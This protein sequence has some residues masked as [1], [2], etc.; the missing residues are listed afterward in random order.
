MI[1]LSDKIPWFGSKTGY[2]C[3]P[4]QLRSQDLAVHEICPRRT[5]FNRAVG[6]MASLALRSGS[7]DQIASCGRFYS[8]LSLL[9]NR[10]QGMHILYGEVHAPA[11]GNYPL[12][13]R[14]RTLLTFHQPRSQWV[15]EKL[16]DLKSVKHALF[17]Y[18]RDMAFFSDQ[19]PEAEV[20]FIPHGADTDFF[21][22]SEYKDG[23]SLRVLYNG[24]HLR[25]IAM[26]RRLFP[27]LH[28]RFPEVRFDFLVPVHRRSWEAFG[29]LLSHPSITWH[30]GLDDNQ[31]LALYQSADL[32]W[33]PMEDSGAN[34]AV[35]EALAC[36]LP[37]V[38]TDVGGIRD[39][40][41]GTIYPLVKNDDDQG[42]FKELETLI[43]RDD[44]RT[45]RSHAARRFTEQFLAWPEIAKKHHMLY[46]EL[47]K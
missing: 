10:R 39:Y 23:K 9:A 11:W 27:E 19:M 42:M 26:L 4:Q 43:T 1:L 20:H 30:S 6:K 22:P 14:Q 25:N 15:P 34:T 41:G 44:V 24:V 35:V 29:E 5:L 32:L 33:L 8:A 28:S 21:R 2:E 31:L 36:G 12:T 16:A 37:I 7:C 38:T 3:L 13:L 40:G 18:Q 17:L 45:E 46:Q 47:F